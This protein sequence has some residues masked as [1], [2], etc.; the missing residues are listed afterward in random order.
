L[1]PLG[2]DDEFAINATLT[3]GTSSDGIA[4]LTE[5][6]T[7]HVGSVS[8]TIPA[9]S[10][11][12]HPAKKKQPSQYTFAGIIDG[13]SLNAKITPL[14]GNLFEFK[15]SGIGVDL[16]GT[17]NPVTVGLLL[18]DDQGGAEVTAAIIIQ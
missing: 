8:A 7:I 18:G 3:L 10:F 4:P 16:T 12:F 11:T 6:V 1:G 2:N 17:V 5:A 13:V 9:G 14:G 15:A